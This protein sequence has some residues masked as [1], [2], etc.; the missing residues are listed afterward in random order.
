MAMISARVRAHVLALIECPFAGQYMYIILVLRRASIAIDRPET[1]RR[2]RF[3]F[4]VSAH[5]L[6]IRRAE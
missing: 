4:K 5:A 3:M 2:A 6:E 1:A